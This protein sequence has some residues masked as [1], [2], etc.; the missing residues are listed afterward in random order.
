MRSGYVPQKDACLL[1]VCDAAVNAEGLGR[2]RLSRSLVQLLSQLAPVGMSIAQQHPY[3]PVAADRRDFRHGKTLLEKSADRLVAQIVEMQIIN[4]CAFRQPIPCETQR[5][6]RDRE[7]A[8]IAGLVL[9]AHHRD[10]R[11][12]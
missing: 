3:V 4:L 12:E 7:D 2:A 8:F 9:L 5:K 10:G 11:F 6:R 1:A